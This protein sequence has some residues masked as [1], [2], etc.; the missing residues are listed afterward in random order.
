M[1]KKKGK[2][3]K[4]KEK[5]KR[6]SRARPSALN[7]DITRRLFISTAKPDLDS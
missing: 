6:S 3:K 1:Q 7:R 2:E 5:K 4:G